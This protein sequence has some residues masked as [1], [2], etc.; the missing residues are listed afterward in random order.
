[1]ESCPSKKGSRSSQENDKELLDTAHC[2]ENLWACQ[3]TV[4]K[5]SHYP[6]PLLPKI[7]NTEKCLSIHC[8]VLFASL[9]AGKAQ[10]WKPKPALT[11][12]AQSCKYQLSPTERARAALENTSILQ[13]R[14]PVRTV[15]LKLTGKAVFVSKCLYLKTRGR[16]RHLKFRLIG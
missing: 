6:S 4:L 13:N 14:P 7:T 2:N 5:G 15:S 8:H 1:M 16:I 11:S 10:L 9:S 3:L 12:I